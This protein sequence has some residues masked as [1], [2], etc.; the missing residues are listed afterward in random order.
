MCF[1]R[2]LLKCKMLENRFKKRQTTTVI[3]NCQIRNTNY[4]I[5]VA[6]HGEDSD[7]RIQAA[8]RVQTEES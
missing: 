7:F 5:V 4:W 1:D 8:V 6:L 3:V 2:Q